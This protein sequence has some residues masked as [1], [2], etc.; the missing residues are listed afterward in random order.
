MLS[1]LD[2]QQT[3]ARIV[4]DHSECAVVFQKNRIDYCCKGGVSLRDACAERGL[5]P[6]KLVAELEHAIAERTGGAEADPRELSTAGLVGHIVSK[7]H[8]YLRKAL[9]FVQGL[10]AKVR[11]VHGE[12]DPRLLE[13]DEI[14]QGLVTALGPHLDEEEQTLFPELMRKTPDHAVVARELATMMKDHLAVGALLGRM[15]TTT[16]DFATPEWAC[17]SYRTLFAELERLE[18]DVL[19]HVHLENHVLMPRFAEA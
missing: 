1:T 7:H 2:P 15:R 13:L 10:A 14:V 16:A 17:N 4:L 3:V 11:R 9:P 8:E 6:A 12:H 5:E 19:R 18:G